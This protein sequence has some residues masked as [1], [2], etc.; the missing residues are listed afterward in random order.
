MTN[1]QSKKLGIIGGMGPAASLLFY[2][3]VIKNTAASRDQE[4]IDMVILNHATIPDR[5]EALAGGGRGELLAKLTEDAKTLEAIGADALAITCNTSHVLAGEIA[6]SVNIPLINM[7]KEAASEARRRFAGKFENG[8]GEAAKIANLATDGTIN[9]KIYQEEHERAGLRPYVP[10][11]ES[12]RLIMSLIYDGV[13]AGG[14]ICIYDCK[15]IE[16]E[17]NS[18][19][20]AGAILACTE[21]SV[22]KEKYLLLDFYVDAMLALARACIRFA[23]KQLQSP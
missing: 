5:T 2:E 10:T 16:D 18:A 13:K 1:E 15:N 22:L 12:Q 20:C 19:G 14:K 23:G 6:A 11:A 7:V 8:N 9:S 4:H 3:M 17:L 21:L